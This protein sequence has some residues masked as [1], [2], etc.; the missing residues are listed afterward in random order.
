MPLSR[1]TNPFL[2]SNGSLTNIKSPSANTITANTSGTQAW[3]IDSNGRFNIASSGSSSSRL[4]VLSPYK[5]QPG[6]EVGTNADTYGTGNGSY[7]PYN[8]TGTA[9]E[10]SNTNA[11]NDAVSLIN[12]DMMD[13]D[14]RNCGVWMGGLTNNG[15]TNGGANMVFGRRTGTSTFAESARFN[16]SGYFGLGT[17][18]PKAQIQTSTDGIIGRTKWLNAVNASRTSSGDTRVIT[19][20]NPS[21]EYYLEM[22]IVGLWPYS[23]DGYG[24]R[25]IEVAG[26][27]SENRYT[28]ITNTGYAGGANAT[29]T[30]GASG[31]NLTVTVVYGN[32]YRFGAFTRLVYGNLD[33]YVTING[34]DN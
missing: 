32:V 29:F 17:T 28:T 13:A 21:G 22:F 30:I 34:T 1:I 15:V 16:P 14:T 5:S 23:G 12:W 24:V 18:S 7:S 27:G 6:I 10:L 19:V 33:S 2:S 31:G 3:A 25:K 11:A 20:V 4:R 9:I 26:F 8:P